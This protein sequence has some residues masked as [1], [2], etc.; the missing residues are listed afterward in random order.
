M[1]NAK[2][3]TYK[4]ELDS[5]DAWKLI[6]FSKGGS[7]TYLYKDNKKRENI[8]IIISNCVTVVNVRLW[9]KKFA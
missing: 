6:L 5:Q 4:C 7:C 8:I 3:Y 2:T 9:I 1:V